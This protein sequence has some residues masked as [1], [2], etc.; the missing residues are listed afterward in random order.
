MLKNVRKDR[1]HK[2][3][4]RLE[5]RKKRKAKTHTKKGRQ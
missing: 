4:K 1:K 3:Q 5:Y 2:T